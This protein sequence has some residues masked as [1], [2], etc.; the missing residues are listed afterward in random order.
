MDVLLMTPNPMRWSDP[1]SVDVFSEHPGLLDVYAQD[2]RDVAHDENVDL[3]DVLSVF[4]GYGD[5]PGRSINDLQLSGDGIHPNTDGQRLVCR[6][7][8]ERI[9]AGFEIVGWQQAGQ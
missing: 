8:T 6:L 9:A 7:L 4:E 3:I 5:E 1:Y 2:V